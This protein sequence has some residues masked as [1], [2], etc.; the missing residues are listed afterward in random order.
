M[1]ELKKRIASSVLS[2]MSPFG[3]TSN[4]TYIIIIDKNFVN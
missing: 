1:K 2:T 3:A 4:S